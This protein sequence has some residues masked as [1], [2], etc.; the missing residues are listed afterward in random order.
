[1]PSFN[2]LTANAGVASTKQI[3]AHDAAILKLD[4]FFR[5]PETANVTSRHQVRFYL[6]TILHGNFAA[7]GTK[8]NPFNAFGIDMV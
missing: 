2:E 3:Q 4:D 7:T 6:L 5:F 1:M 8:P